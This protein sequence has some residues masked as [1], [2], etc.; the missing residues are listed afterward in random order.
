[1][2][3]L[4]SSADDASLGSAGEFHRRLTLVSRDIVETADA[5]RVA[6]MGLEQSSVSAIFERNGRPPSQIEFHCDTFDGQSDVRLT[7]GVRVLRGA[8]MIAAEERAAL[9][10]AESDRDGLG[11]P[12]EASTDD[13]LRTM[14]REIER[15]PLRGGFFMR[16]FCGIDGGELPY[17]ALA[18][19][20]RFEDRVGEYR[21][22]KLEG[23]SEIDVEQ[24][25]DEVGQ[26]NAP[27]VYGQLE[28]A[29]RYRI[30]LATN[31]LSFN[32]PAAEDE[33]WG[34]FESLAP[35]AAEAALIFVDLN[36]LDAALRAALAQ[37][38]SKSG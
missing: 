15:D 25:F 19:A 36:D 11:L 35:T 29:K 17:E 21:I 2:K 13:F 6:L 28:S 7:R 14:T 22:E 33:T 1:M 27:M 3:T 8:E 24:S 37:V 10:Y 4:Q 26:L 30:D 34:D 32:R 23:S 9:E 12:P 18:R 38:R 31:E 16:G 5:L 20:G